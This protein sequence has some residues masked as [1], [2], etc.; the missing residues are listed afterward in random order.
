MRI[1]AGN[2]KVKTSFEVLL[3]RKSIR[4][5]IEEQVVYG[6]LGDNEEAIWSFLPSL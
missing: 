1:A 3:E 2:K 4:R 6:A 5:L